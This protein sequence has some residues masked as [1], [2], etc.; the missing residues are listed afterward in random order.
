MEYNYIDVIIA[1]I[2]VYGIIRGAVNGLIVELASLLALILG[3][4]GA[5]HFSDIVG[6]YLSQHVNWEEKYISLSSFVITFLGIM[7]AVSYL[8]RALTSVASVIAL[9]W[10]NR[11]LGAAFGFLKY[12]FMLSIISVIFL[13]INSQFEIVERTIL[14]ESIL[15]EDLARFAPKIIPSLQDFEIQ[16]WW[17]KAYERIEDSIKEI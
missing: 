17:D 5:I 8:G 1:L 4:W 11:L 16:E 6:Q 7:I 15:F 13:Q 14:K 10:L 3:V 2:L 12:S 9:G